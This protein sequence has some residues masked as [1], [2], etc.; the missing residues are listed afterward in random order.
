MSMNL[1]KRKIFETPNRNLAERKKNLRSVV[2]P[3]GHCLLMLKCTRTETTNK[4]ISKKTGGTESNKL[5]YEP[6]TRNDFREINNQ[7]HQMEE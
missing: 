4:Q 7:F 2:E 6:I 3:Y 1:I 5:E